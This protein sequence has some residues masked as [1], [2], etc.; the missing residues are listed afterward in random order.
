MGKVLAAQRAE[1]EAEVKNE[2]V[3][4]K[5]RSLCAKISETQLD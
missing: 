4:P 3:T 2:P 5:V 1:M